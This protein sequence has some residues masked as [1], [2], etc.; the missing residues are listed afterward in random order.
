MNITE[1]LARCERGGAGL[2]IAEIMA[3]CPF[4]ACL[5]EAGIWDG[6]MPP[7]DGVIIVAA[8]SPFSAEARAWLLEK[9]QDDGD[10]VL[11]VS[12][13]PSLLHAALDELVLD[14]VPPMGRA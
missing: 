1:L 14:L 11:M 12:D 6:K 8:E 4:V 3:V 2:E 10:T 7:I 13:Q 9:L 5:T